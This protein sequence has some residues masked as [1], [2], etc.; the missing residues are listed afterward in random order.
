MSV[1]NKWSK[2]NTSSLHVVLPIV[3]SK[4]TYSVTMYKDFKTIMNIWYSGE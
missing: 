3:L 4:E 2:D 1:E